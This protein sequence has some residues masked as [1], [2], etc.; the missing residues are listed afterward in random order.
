MGG[1]FEKAE[2]RLSDGRKEYI[3]WTDGPN[4]S[5]DGHTKT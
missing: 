4:L 5:I 1:G 2:L 3:G